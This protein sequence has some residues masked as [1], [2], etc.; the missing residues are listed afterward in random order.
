MS[1]SEVIEVTRGF[2]MLDE[3]TDPR[4]VEGRGRPMTRGLM[5]STLNQNYPRWQQIPGL[6]GEIEAIIVEAYKKH[7]IPE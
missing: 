2:M 3:V 4:A 5:L 6:E 7:N 1:R